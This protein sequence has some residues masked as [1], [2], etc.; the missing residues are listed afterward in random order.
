LLYRLGCNNH[1]RIEAALAVAM[2]LALSVASSTSSLER[3][4]NFVGCSVSWLAVYKEN[5]MRRCPSLCPFLSRVACCFVG[6]F[7]HRKEA[8]LSVGFQ[9]LS[10]A[11]SL[12]LES[13]LLLCRLLSS[14]KRSRFVGRFAIFSPEMTPLSRVVCRFLSRDDAARLPLCQSLRRFL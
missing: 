7:H 12:S 3:R 14:S 6:Y 10:V 2:S 11:L 13:C 5:K 4:S 1:W 8:A 9:A